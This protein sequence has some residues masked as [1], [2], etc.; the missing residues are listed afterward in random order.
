MGAYLFVPASYIKS[1]PDSITWEDVAL[2][3]KFRRFDNTSSTRLEIQTVV[4]AF[5]EIQKTILNQSQIMLQVYTDSQC[6]AGLSERRSKLSS[7]CFRSQ[8][9]GQPLKNADL[10]RAF[11]EFHDRVGFSIIKVKGHMRASSRD[12]VH[13]IFACVDQEVR[14][15]LKNCNGEFS[16]GT[17]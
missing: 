7:R 5:G 11:Y 13:H 6:V 10:Y 9:T 14:K 16:T 8:K 1:H 4:W 17:T 2:Q 15:V 12:S 3:L